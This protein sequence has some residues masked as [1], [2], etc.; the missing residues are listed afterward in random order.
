MRASPAGDRPGD[1]RSG[2]VTAAP[3]AVDAFRCDV[4]SAH[5]LAELAQAPLPLAL[6]ASPPVRAVYRDLYL[7]T[8]DDALRRRGAVCRLRLG[9]DGR[10]VLSLALGPRT[11]RAA[12][13][14]A[15]PRAALAEAGAVERW[16]R[17]LA[18]PALLDVRVELE[19]ER[20][21]R[22]ALPDWLRRPRLELHYDQVTVRRNGSARSFHQLCGHRRRGRGDELARLAHAFEREHGLRRG[23]GR[24]ERA[25]LLLKWMPAD[26]VGPG[27]HD[28]AQLY[29]VPGTG[30]GGPSAEFLDPELSL[31]AFQERVLALAEDPATPLGERL[32]FLAIVSANV[33]EFFMVRVAGLRSAAREEMEEQGERELTALEQLEAIGERVAALVAR[34]SRC[35]RACAAELAAHGTRICTWEELDAG[36]RARLREHFR[37]E[38]LPALTPF[39]MTLSPGHP[40]PHLRHLTLSMALV[41]SG[42]DGRASHFA[43]LE[44]PRGVPRFLPAGPAAAGGASARP[45]ARIVVPLEEVIRGNLDLLY[46]EA[47]VEQAYLFRVTRGADLA[48]DEDRAGDLLKAMAAV[49]SRRSHGA[50]VRVEVERAMPRL[51]RSLV[52]EDLRRERAGGAELGPGDVHEVDGLVDLRCLEELARPGGALPAYPPFSGA[53]AVPP[54]RAVLDAVRERDLLV[55]HPFEDFAGSVVRFLR[56]A[57]ADPDVVAIKITLYRIGESSP[58]VAALLDAAARGKQVV[59]F[60]E[61]KARFEE[62][63]NVGWARALEAAGG[64]LVYGLVGLKN[65]AKVALVVRREPGKL[66]RYVHVGTG[67][68][69]ARSGLAYTDLS[70][71]STDEALA[72][73]VAELFNELTGSSAPPQ[74]LARGALVAPQQ[75]LPAL[76]ELIEREAA[77]ARAGRPAGIRMKLNGL[78]DAEVVRALY[79]ASGDGVR[80]ELV[81]RGICTLRPGAPGLSDRIRVVSVVGR[82]LEHSRVYRFTNG[83]EPVHYIGS[84]DLRP[85]NLRRRIELLVPVRDP[86]CRARLDRVLDLYLTDPTA[87][88]LDATGRYERRRGGGAGAQEVLMSEASEAR[89][90]ARGER[91][92]EGRGTRREEGGGKREEERGATDTPADHA[93]GRRH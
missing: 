28:S 86:A 8:P 64:R 18:D 67:N 10:H 62:E 2:R 71:F 56:E 4:V 13:R 83:G 57:A 52:L 36:E 78:S 33:D 37:E 70:L 3:P 32:R 63:R 50:A 41:L 87:W 43:E 44:L 53:H 59:A 69:N 31:L 1:D 47:R 65:H 39:A 22:T 14:A 89:D 20:W 77:H 23:A 6:D 74:R 16:L 60:V 7:D 58:I 26:G 17:A 42:R 73:D 25:E 88:E 66:R 45:P 61:L 81:V 72:G 9:G 48:L 92:E 90:G 27:A 79:R 51:L 40:L 46:P 29:R 68:Y 85:R 84:P 11:L 54:G 76:L 12:V 34:Q 5:Q 19:V 80:V 75:L 24:R 38:L 15:E 49:T 82:F 93:P 21:V 35:Y 91:D 30:P 55:H